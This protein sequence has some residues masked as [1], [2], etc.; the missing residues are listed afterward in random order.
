MKKRKSSL[1]HVNPDIY[2]NTSKPRKKGS[3]KKPDWI[4]STPYIVNGGYSGY[5][6]KCPQ[7]QG[8]YNNPSYKNC[9]YVCPFCSYI[10]LG[11]SKIKVVK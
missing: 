9:V 5:R 11:M 1:S 4:P 7:C 6:Y 3:I 2:K 8:E 10:M